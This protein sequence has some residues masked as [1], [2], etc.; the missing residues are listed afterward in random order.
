MITY[1]IAKFISL[2]ILF[3][4]FYRPPNSD[5][6]NYSTIED[7]V[8]LAVDTGI[9]DIIVTGDFNL[10]MPNP[11]TARKIS[12]FCDQFSLH[13]M[14]KDPTHFTENSSSL[15]DLVLQRNEN[16]VIHCGV[17]DPFL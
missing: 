13:Q 1:K 14:I 3:S 9:S 12:S 7:S 4:L 8:H 5:S 11:Q 17:G 10:N 15:I 16:H 6:V 2:S